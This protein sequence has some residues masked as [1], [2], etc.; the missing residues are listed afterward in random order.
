VK[1]GKSNLN[2]DWLATQ[3]GSPSR[4]PLPPASMNDVALFV[5]CHNFIDVDAASG[6]TPAMATGICARPWNFA[7][8]IA[9]VEANERRFRRRGPYKRPAKE[10]A[11]ADDLRPETN[12]L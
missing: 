3:Y 7:D 12:R 1:V 5:A 8:V 10:I 9:M 2:L 4:E 6:T 11:E